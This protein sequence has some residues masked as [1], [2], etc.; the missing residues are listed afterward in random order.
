MVLARSPV[1]D[2]LC[3]G[4]W[5]R[6]LQLVASLA[7]A[8]GRV[9]ADEGDQ[10]EQ[11]RRPSRRPSRSRRRRDAGP[12]LAGCAARLMPVLTKS[13]HADVDSRP[14]HRPWATLCIADGNILPGMP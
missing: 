12:T 3:C 14:R 7:W 1:K 9:N 5:Q 8:D 6:T 10:K 4:A 2:P 11:L 13:T